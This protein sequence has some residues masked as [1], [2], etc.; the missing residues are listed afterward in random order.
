MLP[1]GYAAEDA[2]PN[3]RHTQR[4]PISEFAKEL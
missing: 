3:A 1:L 2:G 4:N